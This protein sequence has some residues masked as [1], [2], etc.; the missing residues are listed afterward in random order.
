MYFEK[1]KMIKTSDFQAVSPR[2]LSELLCN[3]SLMYNISTRAQYAQYSRQFDEDLKKL[4]GE[5]F[6]RHSKIFG[7]TAQPRWTFLT[8]AEIGMF[9]LHLSVQNLTIPSPW[10]NSPNNNSMAFYHIIRRH[11]NKRLGVIGMP[12]NS[13]HFLNF[14]RMASNH[15]RPCLTPI[16]S[17]L[18][19]LLTS[20][21]GPS[22]TMA[23]LQ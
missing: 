11:N 7:K 17:C 18:G 13:E 1:I 20:N 9:L 19:S 2:R 21:A 5:H 8:N 23:D 3:N 10:V 6:P 4:K 15:L 14:P 22:K 16:I 12:S